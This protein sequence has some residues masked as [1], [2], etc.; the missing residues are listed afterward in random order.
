MLFV[1]MDDVVAGW[2]EQYAIFKTD[3]ITPEMVPEG[4]HLYRRLLPNTGIINAIRKA[5]ET[6]VDV[7]ILTSV[8]TVEDPYEQTREDKVEWLHEHMPFIDTDSQ[9]ICVANDGGSVGIIKAKA[10]EEKLGR[11]LNKKDILMDDYLCNV[12]E[13]Y[14]FGGTPI[15]VIAQGSSNFGSV[16]YNDRSDDVYRCIKKLLNT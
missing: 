3:W 11:A 16:M 1:D 5:Q 2:E 9:F 10:A 14:N 15:H 4:Y 12:S 7:C 13:W 8:Y 6:G